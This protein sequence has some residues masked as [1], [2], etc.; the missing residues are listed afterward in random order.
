MLTGDQDD[1]RFAAVSIADMEV[2]KPA[3]ITEGDTAPS[4]ETVASNA[5]I[6]LRLSQRR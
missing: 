2:A 5:V 1:D 4:I 6:D 3:E